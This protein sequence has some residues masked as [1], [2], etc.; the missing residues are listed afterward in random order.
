MKEWIIGTA[1]V[2]IL[3]AP[4]LAQEDAKAEGGGKA[5]TAEAEFVNAKGEKIGSATLTQTPHGVLIQVEIRGLPPGEHAFHIHETG[6]CDASGQFRSAGGHYAPR[7][8]SHGF[9]VE[10]G[11]HAGDMPNQYVSK[12]GVLRADVVNPRV[13]LGSGKASLFDDDGSA[14]VVHAGADDYSSQPSGDAGD[15]LACA[16]IERS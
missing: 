13:T 16:V 9:M 12:D 3:S 2:A 1:L 4:A 6:K 7:G 10:D 11:P 8:K 5:R 15:R 14:L